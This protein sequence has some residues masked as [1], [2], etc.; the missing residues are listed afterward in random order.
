MIDPPVAQRHGGF[1][2]AVRPQ[3][4][5]SPQT[6][7]LCYITLRRLRVANQGLPLKP[8]APAHHTAM[9]SVDIASA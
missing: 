3:E 1:S 6:A 5:F 7:S 8:H 9:A 2:Y 4:A